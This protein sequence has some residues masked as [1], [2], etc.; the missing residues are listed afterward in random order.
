[1]TVERSKKANTEKPNGARKEEIGAVECRGLRIK[2]AGMHLENST[3][4]AKI[5]RRNFLAWLWYHVQG[6]KD[7]KNRNM[8]SNPYVRMYG[9]LI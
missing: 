8:H 5:L 2:E 1:M 9:V 4:K 6:M 3:Y 7:L